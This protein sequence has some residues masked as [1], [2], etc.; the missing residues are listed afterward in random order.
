MSYYITCLA[1]DVA[2]FKQ[3]RHKKR[4][5]FPRNVALLAD[6]AVSHQPVTTPLRLCT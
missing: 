4:G 6:V 5:S 2:R 3:L 1:I